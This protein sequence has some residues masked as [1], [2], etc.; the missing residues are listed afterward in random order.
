[1]S[2]NGSMPP[3][4]SAAERRQ[5]EGEEKM[6][7][8]GPGGK[9]PLATEPVGKLLPKFA[10]PM[11]ISQLVSSVY[12]I[13]DQI[14]IGQ[15]VG[16]LGN[17]ATTVCFPLVNICT[18][19]ALLFGI[20]GASNFSLKMGSG[21]EEGAPYFIGNSL[22]LLLLAGVTVSSV[23]LLR[24]RPMLILFGATEETL[25]YAASY[26]GITA[27][28]IPF[29]IL[30]IGGSLLIRAD[31]SP[32][33]AMGAVLSGA[34]L[35][36][37]LD[38]IFI[39]GL[40]WG[41]AG[42][43][44]A[45]IIGQILSGVIVLL[46]FRHC[47]MCRLRKAHF[48][49][50]FARLRAIPALGMAAG[51]N[52]V[53]LTVVNVVMNNTLR[54][55]GALSIY[56]SDIPIACVGI[57]TKVNVLV[58]AFIIGIA[59]GCQPINGF[60]Y[61]AKQ[62]ERVKLT[63]LTALKAVTMITTVAFALFQIFPRQIIGI[64]GSGSEEYF[65]FGIRYLRIYLLMTFVNGI[66][67]LTSNFFTSIGKAWKGAFLSL[68]RQFLFLLPLILFLP[69]LFGIDGVLYA[70]PIADGMAFVTAMLLVRGEYRNLD[71]LIA[72]QEHPEPT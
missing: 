15:S 26:A 22:L 49:L 58:L 65:T 48:R 27:F 55:Y 1:M 46:Y 38:P 32:K 17:A 23:A 13:V 18:A 20:G 43:A 11:I 56:G 57:I 31:Q 19:C 6:E 45:T 40:G 59:Q 35:N 25:G 3:P 9:N 50:N 64:F 69:H 2:G 7:R 70:G 62:Y 67:P 5:T 33:Y 28:G 21:D 53:A 24:L 61:G 34:I 47:K 63:Y 37:I 10:I 41:I 68:T 42:A 30:S 8:V 71:K 36:C 29:L 51:L 14:F 52:Q 16:Y 66:Q 72:M 39:F 44:Y 12:N 54:Y 4:R 60:N